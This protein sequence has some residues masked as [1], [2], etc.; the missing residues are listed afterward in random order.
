MRQSLLAAR[1]RQGATALSARQALAI[2]TIGSARCLGRQDEIG[3]L[4]VGKQ[5]DVALWRLDD[6]GHAAEADPVWAL[7]CGPPARLEL[8]TVA[9]RPVVEAGRLCTADPVALGRDVRAAARAL[10]G[11][12]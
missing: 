9:G 11:R 6:L 2:A 4:E 10:T 3:S 1:A 5:A 7:V 8:L 12:H